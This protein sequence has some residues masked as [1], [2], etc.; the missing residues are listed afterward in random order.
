[1]PRTSP[2][3][4]AASCATRRGPPASAFQADGSTRLALA[5]AFPISIDASSYSDLAARPDIQARAAEI[6]EGLG[7]PRTVFLGVDRLD[8]TKGIRHRLKAFGELLE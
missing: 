2:A 1:M 5:K 3:P 7:N 6:R 4:C 8:Y